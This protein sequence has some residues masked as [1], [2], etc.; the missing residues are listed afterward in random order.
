MSRPNVRFVPKKSLE[1]PSELF[2]AQPNTFNRPYRLPTSFFSFPIP[3]FLSLELWIS[4]QLSFNQGAV[5]AV[6]VVPEQLYSVVLAVPSVRKYS[7]PGPLGDVPQ[8]AEGAPV[9]AEIDAPP[10]RRS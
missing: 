7:D 2:S 8:A 6:Q 3:P 5:T 9:P 10:C 1:R 4:H